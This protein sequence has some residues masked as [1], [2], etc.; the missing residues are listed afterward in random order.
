M[1]KRWMFYV[2]AG[3]IFG[4]GYWHYLGRTA[5]FFNDMSSHENTI[6]QGWLLILA[7][8]TYF[9]VWLIPAILPAIYEF[10]NSSSVR[11]SV[12]AVV[13]AWLSSVVGYY[14]NYLV[15]LAFIGLP[16][17][18]F[19]VVSGQQTSTFWQDWANFFPKLILYN[20]IKWIGIG[21]ILSGMAGLI[22]SSVYSVLSKKTNKTSAV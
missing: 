1:K 10:R 21:V 2:F 3:L 16:N 12:I 5:K 4:A 8:L 14:V 11:I 6:G 9:G 13:T 7:L 17:M 19:L 22:T 18:E 20:L 15:M